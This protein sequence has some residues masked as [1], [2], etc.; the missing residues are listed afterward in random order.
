MRYRFNLTKLDRTVKEDND[1]LGVD[2]KKGDVVVAWMSATNMDEEMFEDAFTLNIHRPNN[3][4]HLAFGN[5][6]HFCLGAPL[7]RLEAKIALTTFLE[8]YS[9]IESVDSFQ[10]EE[11]LTDSA[12]GQTLTSLPLKAFSKH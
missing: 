4:K 6:P 11:N 2:L 5:G 10:L 12:T 1:L 7:A 3:K 9:H 8:K